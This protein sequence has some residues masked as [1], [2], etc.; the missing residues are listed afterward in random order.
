MCEQSLLHLQESGSWDS[1]AKA[2]TPKDT[3]KQMIEKNIFKEISTGAMRESNNW[4]YGK[5]Q[6]LSEGVY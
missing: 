5:R 4:M 6:A 1:M 2:R 3:A